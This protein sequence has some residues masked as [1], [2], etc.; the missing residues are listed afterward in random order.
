GRGGWFD[1]PRA[2]DGRESR[3]RYASRRA[4]VGTGRGGGADADGAARLAL[5]PHD[6]NGPRAVDGREIARRRCGAWLVSR[7][8][9]DAVAGWPALRRAADVH[10]SAPDG[11][12][13]SHLVDTLRPG[14]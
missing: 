10:A 6:G 5:V 14:H 4:P 1:A 13:A 12:L 8:R 11:H 7:R 9:R 3:D 2:R